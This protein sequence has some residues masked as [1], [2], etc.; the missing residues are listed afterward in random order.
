MKLIVTADDFGI[1]DAATDGI[2]KC[3]RVGVLT[4]TG[5]FSN[6]PGAKYAVDRLMRECPH[7]CLG[8]D[9]N[10][11]A[12][13]P[14]TDPKLIP[15]LVQE[16]GYFKTSGMHRILDK[17]SPNHISY[18]EACLETENQ[19]KKFIELA[20]KK[21]EYLSGHA[22]GCENTH[23]ALRD[24]AAKY[25]IPLSQDLYEKIGVASGTNTAIWN[26]LDGMTTNGKWD[27]SVETQ[28]SRDP[29]QMFIDGKIEYL[30]KALENDGIAHIHTH[31]GF[32]DRDLFRR[33]SF[34]LIRAMEADFICSEELINWV[35][36]NNVELVSF[37]DFK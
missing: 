26:A 5:L 22:Y 24:I 8:E 1:S 30:Q 25:E 12:G 14:V 6:M 11:V 27:F 7:V 28:L 16:N 32:V 20:G 17:T 9:I 21:P 36:T 19:I 31:A 13:K 4:Q 18:E 2:I 29:L 34:T 10:L 37:K 33:S 35:K 23:K 15:T 3:G